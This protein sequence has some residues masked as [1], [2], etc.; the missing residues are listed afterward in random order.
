VPDDYI[1]PSDPRRPLDYASGPA[2]RRREPMSGCMLAFV[3]VMVVLG[4]LIG[5]CFLMVSR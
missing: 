4:L 5:T 3:I 2:R 1:D